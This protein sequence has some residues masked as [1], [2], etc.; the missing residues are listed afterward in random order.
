MNSAAE[1]QICCVSEKT[2]QRDACSSPPSIT[3]ALTA[4]HGTCSPRIRPGTVKRT[5]I[6]SLQ[7]HSTLFDLTR[8]TCHHA[9][10][11]RH[12]TGFYSSSALLSFLSRVT[13]MRSQEDFSNIF[14]SSEGE[15]CATLHLTHTYRG[16]L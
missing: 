5:R 11:H 6:S 9:E 7:I 8:A 1:L 3:G 12:I 14:H 2:S 16:Q 13:S 4:D 15:I 10:P